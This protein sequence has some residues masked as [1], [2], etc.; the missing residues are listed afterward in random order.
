MSAGK[1]RSM[2][3]KR[4]NTHGYH[5]EAGPIGCD[6]MSWPNR[7]REMHRPMLPYGRPA[8]GEVEEAPVAETERMKPSLGNRKPDS[9][10]EDL[11]SSDE[12]GRQSRQTRVAVLKQREAA[13]AA[14][15]QTEA[16]VLPTAPSFASLFPTLDDSQLDRLVTMLEEERRRRRQTGWNSQTGQFTA[17]GRR[18]ARPW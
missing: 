7:L 1:D 4:A 5:M 10:W 2:C 18:F 6:K 15:R 8:K 13:A 14:L 12:E 3:D 11:T 16:E 9:D 17:V